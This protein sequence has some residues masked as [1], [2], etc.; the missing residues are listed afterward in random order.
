MIESPDSGFPTI[1]KAISTLDDR[2]FKKRTFSVTGLHNL[3]EKGRRGKAKSGKT[4]DRKKSVAMKHFIS[5][6]LHAAMY[7]SLFSKIFGRRQAHVRPPSA[8]R[9]VPPL[10]SLAG[11]AGV[12]R[13]RRAA[14]PTSKFVFGLPA[15]RVLL[16]GSRRLEPQ[17]SVC[18]CSAELGAGGGGVAQRRR[19]RDPGLLCKAAP[20]LKIRFFSIPRAANPHALKTHKTPPAA[21]PPCTS[22]ISH[23]SQPKSPFFAAAGAHWLC[24][25][26][27]QSAGGAASDLSTPAARLV[28]SPVGLKLTSNSMLRVTLAEQPNILR[29]VRALKRIKEG[30]KG[31]GRR[32][33]DGRLNERVAAEVVGSTRN[34]PIIWK[35]CEATDTAPSMWPAELAGVRR[36]GY[37]RTYNSEKLLPGV[38]KGGLTHEKEKNATLIWLYPSFRQFHSARGLCSV[39]TRPADI[40]T[41][42][43]VSS[44][45]LTNAFLLRS[46]QW[47]QRRAVSSAQRSG[48]GVENPSRP[49][50][51][52]QPHEKKPD[53]MQLGIGILKLPHADSHK[54][55]HFIER[56]LHAVVL[57]EIR[58]GDNFSVGQVGQREN[59]GKRDVTRDQKFPAPVEP[60]VIYRW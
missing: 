40:Y 19:S 46:T 41:F 44:S 33:G 13:R 52:P 2:L 17:F 49:G 20:Q 55:C 10:I 26:E 45:N 54:N 47:A 28:K 59:G 57:R 51:R 25:V 1:P 48:S 60:P 36:V 37:L 15:S 50:R 21:P 31:D 8:M 34:T 14:A 42:A 56:M 22:R 11:I 16:H 23:T 27:S 30:K 38:Y 39:T 58:W 5:V 4:G 7:V 35:G 32:L 24:E 12:P 43:E 9:R 53:Q 6:R 18:Y 3:N 29:S